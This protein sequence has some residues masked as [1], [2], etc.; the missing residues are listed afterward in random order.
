MADG[1]DPADWLSS[2]FGE[3]AP[4]KRRRRSRETPEAEP[5]ADPQPTG[6]GFTWGL[7]P[8]GAASDDAAPE[9]AA[10]GIAAPQPEP[11][12]PAPEAWDTPTVATPVAPE[13]PAPAEPAAAAWDT[14][15][16]ASPTVPAD[17]A[18]TVAYGAEVARQEFPVFGVPVDPSME[19]VTEALGAQPIGL[20]APEDE[21]LE[22]SAIDSLFGEDSFVEYEDSLVPVLPPRASGGELAV[23][24][25]P[26]AAEARAPFTQTQKILVGVAGGLVAVLL[27]IIVF[28]AGQRIAANSPAP[29]AT[30]P[31]PS[32]SALPTTGPLP[33]GE[34]YWDRL[35]GGECL[36]PFTSPWEDT[37][38]VVPCTQPHPAQLVLKGTFPATDDP[39]YPGVD[40]LQ[41]TAAS[42]CSAPTV[43]DYTAAAGVDDIQVLASFAANEQ[44]W[45]GGNRTFYCFA[46]RAGGAELTTSIA[47]P[48]APAP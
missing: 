37:F 10:P 3:E 34:Y 28:L 5:A 40:E 27:L 15:T 4:E 39:A 45:L 6:G 47:Q 32:A 33:P 26:R 24:E 21:G 17:P 22:V 44:D 29:V 12:A 18:P 38:T 19:G 7:T 35:L 46:N 9:E 23:V 31:A 8:G 20:G 11:A 1:L 36:A 43:I 14:P 48:Q 25:R 16:V 30:E 41:A 13:R 42:L 2:Q